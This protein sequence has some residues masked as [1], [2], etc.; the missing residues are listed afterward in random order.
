MNHKFGVTEDG[1]VY[2][3]DKIWNV[4]RLLGRVQCVMGEPTPIGREVRDWWKALMESDEPCPM[5][6]IRNSRVILATG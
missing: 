6:V 2:R 4:W 5:L 1:K 3:Y